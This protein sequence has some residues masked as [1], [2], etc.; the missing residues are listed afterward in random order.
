MSEEGDERQFGSEGDI[1]DAACR[2]GGWKYCCS[3]SF[4]LQ[5]WV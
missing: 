3:K 5:L 4:G 2:N 1:G